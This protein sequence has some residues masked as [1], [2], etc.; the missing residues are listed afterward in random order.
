M[1]SKATTLF[2]TSSPVTQAGFIILIRNHDRAWNDIS[3]FRPRKRGSKQGP[4]ATR[5]RR[6][7]FENLKGA[8]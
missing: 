6:T 8:Y 4:P 5:N 3:Q 2:T 1:L 7:L